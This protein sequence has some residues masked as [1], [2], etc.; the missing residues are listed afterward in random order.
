MSS[1]SRPA[2]GLAV[3][4]SVTLPRDEL[5][6]RYSAAGGPG[7]QHANRNRTRV[8]VVFDVE[9]SGALTD[10][11]RQRVIGKVGSRLTAVAA[12]ARSQTRNRELA[13]Q[14]L[15]EQLRAALSV[16]KSRRATAPTKGSQRRR[17]QH[18]RLRSDLKKGRRRPSRDD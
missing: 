18:K 5:E 6:Y 1:T 7:G 13:E 12:D 15:V 2:D 16:P 3:T 14:R 4:R 17:L 11:Q 10:A 9:A 8:A